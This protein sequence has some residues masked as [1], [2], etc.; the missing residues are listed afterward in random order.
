MKA[1]GSRRRHETEGLAHA[2]TRSQMYY[3]ITL[4]LVVWEE[5]CLLRE[6]GIVS[7]Q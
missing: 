5:G 1:R 4:G 6:D 3:S 7:N 2:T